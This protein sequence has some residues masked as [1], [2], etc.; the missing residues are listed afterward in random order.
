MKFIN[1][2]TKSLNLLQH[3]IKLLYLHII[4]KLIISQNMFNISKIFVINAIIE[5]NPVL[6]STGFEVWLK[7]QVFSNFKLRVASKDSY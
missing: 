6:P 4:N 7:Q 1:H 5:T 3:I 2:I